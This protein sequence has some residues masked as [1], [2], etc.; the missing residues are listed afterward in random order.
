MKKYPIVALIFLLLAAG[1]GAAHAE[2]LT[3]DSVS[4]EYGAGNQ[5]R[6]ARAGLQWNWD[7]L[8]FESNGTHLGGYWDLTVAQL[9]GRDWDGIPNNHHEV[10]DVG[11]TPIFRFENDNKQGLYSE[12]GIGAN[13]MTPVY[14]NNRRQFSTAFQFGDHLGFGYQTSKWSIGLK[15]QHFSNCGIKHPNPGVNFVVVEV[16]FEL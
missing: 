9:Q 2:D 1:I 8:W 11:L 12:L 10:I 6:L 14:D 3:P 13:I 15:L 4:V 7:K 5:T 16:D